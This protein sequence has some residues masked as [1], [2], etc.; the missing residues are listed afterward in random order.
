MEKDLQ[1]I[2]WSI[3]EH[4][5]TVGG[6]KDLSEEATVPPSSVEVAVAAIETG[7]GNGAESEQLTAEVRPAVRRL[8]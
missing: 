2:R 5:E 6:E 3:E 1:R 7:D 8:A 4:M